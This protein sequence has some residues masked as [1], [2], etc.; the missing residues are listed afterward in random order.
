MA[1]SDIPFSSLDALGS[2]Y[3]GIE[4]PNLDAKSLSPFEGERLSMPKPDFSRSQ[5]FVPF[6]PG[7]DNLN[8][9]QGSVR[10]LVGNP[11]SKP[12]TAKKMSPEEFG[13]ALHAHSTAKLNTRQ[14][15]NEYSRIYAYD[16]GPSGNAFYD[17]YKA[18]GQ[19]T[20]DKI[21]FHP[22]RDNE[23]IYN[24]GTTGW[25]DTKRMMNH[26]FWPLFGRGFVAGPKSL[27]KMFQGDFSADPEEGEFYS[28]AAALG[29]STKGGV[30]GFLNNTAMSFGYTAGIITEAVLEEALAI[31]VTALTGGGAAPAAFVATANVG[32]NIMKG[33]KGLD[34]AVDGMKAVNATIKG[35]ES[36]SAARTFWNAARSNTAV[37][38]AA[39][40]LNPLEHLT[41]AAVKIAKNE[42]NLTGLARLTDAGRKTVGGFYGEVRGINMALSEARLEGGMQQN[43]VYNRLY[44][45]YYAKNKQAPSD[46]MQKDMMD[47][48]KK[49]G[50][51]ALQWN[52]ALIFMSNKIVLDNLV[53]VKG[54]GTSFLAAKTKDILNLE[55]GSVSRTLAKQTLKTGKKVLTPT[56]NWRKQTLVNTLRSFAKDPIR[57]SV[58]GGIS[59]FKKNITEALQ[60][61]A[62]DVIA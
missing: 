61:N 43:D 6:H 55:G 26:A 25:Q 42:N 15:K 7:T 54:R 16:A 33:I 35:V 53:G 34:Y 9:N 51:S 24:A 48:A 41:D 60:E 23:A 57:K 5:N 39:R 37:N 46:E 36:V 19:E 4:S 44:D 3:G 18:Y 62:Q 12:A 59:Y 11:I 52:T 58:T 40:F 21:G 22:F 56:L 20:F 8:S 28:R 30:G 29:N 31:G 13:K 49:A 50:V 10:K 27:V 45:E 38:K 1:E 17:R 32:R 47:T 14:D 2:G